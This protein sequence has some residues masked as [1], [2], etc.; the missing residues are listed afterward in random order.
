MDT[1]DPVLDLL[2]RWVAIDSV[3]PSLVPG[4][5]G[6]REM[7][8][9]VAAELTR[10][11]CTVELDEILPG[12]PNV[13]GTLEGRT[14]GPTLLLCGHIDTVSVE[15]MAAPFAPEVRDGRLYGRG[16]YDMKCGVAAMVDAVRLIQEAGGLAAGRLL[17]AGVMDEEHASL[18]TQALARRVKADAAIVTEPTELALVVTHKGFAWVEVETAGIAGHGSRPEQ[19]RDAILDMGRVLGRLERLDRELAAGTPHPLL[20]RASLHASLISGGREL[21]SYPDHCTAQLERRTLPGEPEAGFLDEV[22]GLLA[23]LRAE[24][25]AFRA[26][27]RLLLSRS[28][29]EPCHEG[30]AV[31]LTGLLARE[32]ETRGL[33]SQLQG[34]SFW[35]DAALL[36]AAGIPT[37]LFGPTGHGAHA[38][39]EWVD[40][41]SAVVCRDVLAAVAREFTGR[42]RISR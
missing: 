26:S 11:G 41:E 23:Q 4:A 34:V 24:D 16:A 12:R 36:A 39:E 30:E 6:E 42:E 25:P 10:L 18:G 20:G 38:L 9:A 31:R 32:L 29:L 8:L 7:A 15:G 33:P 22:E 37:L 5:R 19:A 40:T 14:P 13:V 1:N 27:A 35:T 3:N 2:A 17:V 28:P 21:S